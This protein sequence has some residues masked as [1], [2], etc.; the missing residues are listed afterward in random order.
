MKLYMVTRWGNPH[1]KDGP[2]GKDTN[3]LIRAA[4]VKEAG[5]LADDALLNFPISQP[6]NRPAQGFSQCIHQLGEDTISETHGILHGPWIEY[7]IIENSTYD[8]W[9]RE[10]LN[11]EWHNVSE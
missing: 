9:H 4:S 6:G 8:T 1:E 5:Q 3:F 2:D 11:S 10:D 7:A